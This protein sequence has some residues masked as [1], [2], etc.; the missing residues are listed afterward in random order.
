[1]NDVQ[2][3][4]A[5]IT[6]IRAGALGDTLLALPSLALLR[7]AWPQTRIHFVAP[8]EVAALAVASC[9]AD[10]GAPYE[11]PIWAGLFAAPPTAAMQAALREALQGADAAI[12]WF[13]DPGGDIAHTLGAAGVARIVVAPGRPQPGGEHCAL[14]LAQ[15]LRQLDLPVPATV[16]E[17]AALL[18]PL[19]PPPSAL[20]TA[21]A[22]WQAFSLPNT[23]RVVALHAGS[24]GA[25][26]RWPPASFAALALLARAEGYTPLLLAGPQDDAVVGEVVAQAAAAGLAL[27]VA[28]G[29]SL[30]TLAALLASCALYIGNDSGVTHLAALL[31]RP[32][33][34]LFGPSDPAQWAPLGRSARWLRPSS[35]RVADLAPTQVWHE[36]LALL[37]AT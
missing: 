27:P 14:L 15:A 20:A 6:C 11:S 21:A 17:L 4:P 5:R 13:A 3:P 16:A 36:A 23:P 34:A 37:A 18:P 25:A 2:T 26:K 24:G 30:D 33:L 32:T 31:G 29:M 35:Q 22:L 7:R 19:R 10:A 1:M 9:L 28:Q 8:G 12:A